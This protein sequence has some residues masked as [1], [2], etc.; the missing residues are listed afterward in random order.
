MPLTAGTR[1]NKDVRRAPRIDAVE[2][3]PDVATPLLRPMRPN[4]LADR[5]HVTVIARWPVPVM[6]TIE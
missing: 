3:S 4:E 2:R 1:L 6:L 5:L